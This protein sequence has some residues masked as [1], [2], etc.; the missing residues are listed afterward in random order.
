MIMKNYRC[1][2]V[3]ETKKINTKMIITRKITE[4]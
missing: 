4:Q 2:C 1:L 3:V